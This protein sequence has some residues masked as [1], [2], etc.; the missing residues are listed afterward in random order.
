MLGPGSLTMTV[1]AFFGLYRWLEAPGEEKQ[2]RRDPR[3]RSAADG[4]PR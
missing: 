2:A 1:F 3:R 4:V